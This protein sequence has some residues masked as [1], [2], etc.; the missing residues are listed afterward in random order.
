[1]KGLVALA[2]TA[3]WGAPAWTD[4]Q[5]SQALAPFDYVLLVEQEGVRQ[6]W[7][8]RIAATDAFQP[9]STFKLVHA[10]VALDTGV[11]SL[12]D[13]T[14]RCEPR[15]CHDD[16][17]LIDLPGAIQRSCVSYFRQ[18]ARAIGPA[19]MA[20]ALAR[21]GY[22][23]TGTLE[24]LD[25]FWLTGGMRITAEQQARWV[26]R[27]YTTELPVAAEALAAVRAAS[28]LPPEPGCILHGK[29]GSSRQG[30]GWFMGQVTRAGSRA[31]VVVLLKGS[32]ATGREAEQRLRLLLRSSS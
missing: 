24:P 30:F 8:H 3:L 27:F 6:Q 20:Q 29:T 11:V 17:G 2:C 14:R 28:R 1:M 7:T 31:W 10:L 4:R 13:S 5:V 26:R 15:E 23:A 25:R 18:C 16:H 19:R 22:P 21:L 9:C 32:G 12:Q